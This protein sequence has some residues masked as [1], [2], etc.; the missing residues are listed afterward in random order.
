MRKYSKFI[1]VAGALAALAVPS[2]AMADV[3][4]DA[5]GD[6]FVGKGDV[7]TALGYAN[8]N[9]FTDADARSAV[10]TVNGDRT[11]VTMDVQCARTDAAGNDIIRDIVVNLGYI[12][13][14]E[15]TV[16]STP[17]ISG[18]KVTGYNLTGVTTSGW[19]AHLDPQ[20][21]ALNSC[22]AGEHFHAWGGATPGRWIM[23][24]VAG[25]GLQVTIGSKTAP[26]PNT[27][28]AIPAV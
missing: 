6:G 12:A 23:T 11:N 18:G 2:A 22:D 17:K 19:T 27:P 26:L 25:S 9:T 4:V 13:E 7:Q 15:T 8:N 1:V 20:S 28:V 3:N 5:N 24:P 14:N 10:F 16:T 21:K